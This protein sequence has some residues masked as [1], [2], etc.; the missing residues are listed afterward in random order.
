MATEEEIKRLAY[1]IWEKEGRPGG[2][3]VEHY[4]RARQMLGE[5]IPTPVLELASLPP[6]LEL[7]PVTMLAYCVKCRTKRE[8]QNPQLARLSNGRR[9][10]RGACPVCGTRMFRIYK[11]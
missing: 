11:A 4:F 5:K 7:A 1:E 2:R 9:A 6:V 8:I 3:D 10:F